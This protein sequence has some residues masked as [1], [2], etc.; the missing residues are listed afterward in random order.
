MR[1]TGFPAYMEHMNEF[2]AIVHSLGENIVDCIGKDHLQQ[3]TVFG[4]DRSGTAEVEIGLAD[5]TWPEQERAIDRMVE[6]RAMFLD[7]LSISYH[8]VEPDLE[9]ADTPTTAQLV[10]AN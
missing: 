2:Q 5:F 3:V 7:E 1:S 10:F 4:D 6:I 8:F 9:S